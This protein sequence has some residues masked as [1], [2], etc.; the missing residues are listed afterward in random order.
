MHTLFCTAFD[1]GYLLGA[2]VMMYSLHKN[3]NNF[4]QY[5]V[6][7]FHNDDICY[8]S[9]NSRKWLSKIFPNII[10]T[11]IDQKAYLNAHGRPTKPRVFYLAL[12]CFRQFGFE[13]VLY[14]DVDML[15]LSDFTNILNDDFDFAACDDTVDCLNINSL[16]KSEGFP[17]TSHWINAGF[18]IVGKKFINN[19]YYQELI[20]IALSE[21]ELP[22]E[23]QTILNLFLKNKKFKY[24]CL[25]FN[26]N[27]RTLKW[28]KV[29]K[30]KG[31]IA[32]VKIIHFTGPKPWIFS[33]SSDYRFDS[34]YFDI[35]KTY[36]DEFMNKLTLEEQQRLIS[37]TNSPVNN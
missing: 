10:F 6:R 26:Y 35:W 31:D 16:Y 24:Y 23:D 20:D 17:L 34:I 32:D 33:Q 7:I 11:Y 19:Q 9:A 4:S 18:Y 37:I 15:C 36:L 25:P 5:E 27:H 22:Q 21:P 14:F 30:H 13:K 12:E 29:F 8:L 3:I 28:C 2:A 1:D